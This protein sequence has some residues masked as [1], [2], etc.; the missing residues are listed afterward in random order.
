MQ[1]ETGINATIIIAENDDGTGNGAINV[2]INNQQQGQA[3][4]INAMSGFLQPGSGFNFANLFAP[5]P[6]QQQQ[7]P[8][9]QA[10]NQN[11]PSSIPIPQSNQNISP[12]S[13][14]PSNQP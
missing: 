6:P 2:E 11:S 9:Q 13:S 1:N 12:Q 5:Q 8:Q 10:S 4:I 14:N 7:Q 3:N